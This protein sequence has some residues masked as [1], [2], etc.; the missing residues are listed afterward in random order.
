MKGF[1]LFLE[2]SG[3]SSENS[4]LFLYFLMF[5]ACYLCRWWYSF[6]C[7]GAARNLLAL[8]QQIGSDLTALHVLPKLRK[9]FDEL[10]FSQEKAGHSSI[11]G[12]SLRGPNTKK[13]DE[14]KITSRL[15]LVWVSFLFLDRIPSSYYFSYLFMSFIV[16]RMLLYPSFASL[17]GIE[18]LRQCCATWLL[19][20]QFLLRRY[21]W[22]V[23]FL[24]LPGIRF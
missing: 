15:D 1:F 2:I 14:N 7:K 9:L 3:G 6:A 24:I 20:E 17:L 22:K 8:C 19:L 13:E 4:R 16:C 5:Y 10:A 12:G 18:K 21:N 23:C 11:K